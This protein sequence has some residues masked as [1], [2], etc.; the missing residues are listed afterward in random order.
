MNFPV[1]TKEG[2][3]QLKTNTIFHDYLIKQEPYYFSQDLSNIMLEIPHK[4][5]LS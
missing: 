5:Y 2:L 3:I 1:K 4:Y